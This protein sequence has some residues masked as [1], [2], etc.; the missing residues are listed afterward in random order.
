VLDHIVRTKEPKHV[1]ISS[2]GPVPDSSIVAYAG[3]VDDVTRGIQ[4]GHFP[5]TGLQGTACSY[6]GYKDLC[7]PF[8]AASGR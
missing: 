1:A 3:I 8:K 5:P 4:G 2:P 6:C 7:A